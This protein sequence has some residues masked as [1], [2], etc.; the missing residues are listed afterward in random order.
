M[1]SELIA[2]LSKFESLTDLRILHP[3]G[4]L[5]TPI[6]YKHY[7]NFR[8]AAQRLHEN[9]EIADFAKELLE[10]PSLYRAGS[11]TSDLYTKK[12]VSDKHEIRGR[13]EDEPSRS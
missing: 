11:T 13:G 6:D 2:A 7:L 8:L 5:H 1:F 10:L 3:Y 9:E 4:K 12:V